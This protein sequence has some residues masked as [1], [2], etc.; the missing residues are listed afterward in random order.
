MTIIE[1]IRNK[2][3]RESGQS[4]TVQKKT[5]PDQQGSYSYF[6][7]ILKT[8]KPPLPPAPDTKQ[9]EYWFCTGLWVYYKRP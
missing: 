4:C 8:A 9:A 3:M 2:E 7:K 5:M 6:Y 1:Y